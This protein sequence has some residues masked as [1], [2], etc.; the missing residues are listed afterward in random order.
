MDM[1]SYRGTVWQHRLQGSTRGPNV[2]LQL[3]RNGS[4]SGT[5]VLGTPIYSVQ[6]VNVTLE[7]L[8]S[9]QMEPFMGPFG[10]IM[11][12]LGVPLVVPKPDVEPVS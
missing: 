11:C 9:V 10:S 8:K 4:G 5:F 3:C 2:S 1:T 12:K 6:S 7:S